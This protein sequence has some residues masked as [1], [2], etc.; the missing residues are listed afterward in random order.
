MSRTMIL[1]LATA[2]T[3]AV[4]TLASQSAD[5]R[6]FGGGGGFGGGRGFG[7]GGG[8]ARSFGGG[9]MGHVSM[10]HVSMGHINARVARFTPRGPIPIVVPHPHFPG[11]IWAFNHH[12]HWVFRGGRWMFDDVEVDAVAAP[13][14]TTAPGPCT[15]L[16][17]NYTPS[18]LVVFA[19]VCTKESASAPVDSTADA[20]QAPTSPVAAAAVPMSV[21]PTTPNYAGRTYDDYLSANPQAANQQAPQAPQKN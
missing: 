21:V 20:S 8:F 2:A 3:L 19:D 7:G 4:A 9:G 17:K 16:T 1:S 11:H 10:G 5:A 12:H 14:V 13:I 18:G 6:G 15:C